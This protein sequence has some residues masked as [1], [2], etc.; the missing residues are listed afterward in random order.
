MANK[1]RV[2]QHSARCPVALRLF[3]DCNPHYWCFIPLLW[4]EAQTENIA[5]Y[6]TETSS[7]DEDP[8]QTNLIA[9][10]ATSN[11]RLAYCLDRVP[12]PPAAYAFS[13]PQREQQRLFFENFLPSPVDQLPYSPVDLYKVAMIAVRKS[14]S[15]F[16][17]SYYFFQIALVPDDRSIILRYIIETLFIIHGETKLNM[18]CP[19]GGDPEKRYGHPYHLVWCADL[20]RPFVATATST[21]G[22]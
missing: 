12:I 8:E 22:Q 20:N 17:L 19:I 13:Y 10:G 4:H 7:L 14:I 21:Q 5:S 11:Q 3:L 15:I 18:I 1:M 2:Y 6:R 16:I 9:M